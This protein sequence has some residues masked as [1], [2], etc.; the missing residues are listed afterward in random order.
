MLDFLGMGDLVE[1]LFHSPDLLQSL[2]TCIFVVQADAETRQSEAD[3]D[4]IERDFDSV[5]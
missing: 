4:R 5:V 3:F 1:T 2:C